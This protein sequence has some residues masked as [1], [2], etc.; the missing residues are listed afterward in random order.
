MPQSHTSATAAHP[1]RT[2]REPMVGL[3][4]GCWHKP[5]ALWP[6]PP[7][8][9]WV[10]GWQGVTARHPTTITCHVWFISLVEP[11]W[12]MQLGRRPRKA[13]GR[14]SRQE[15]AAT[16]DVAAAAAAVDR[17]VTTAATMVVTAAMTVTAGASAGR[18]QAGLPVAWLCAGQGCAAAVGGGGAAGGVSSGAASPRTAAAFVSACGAAA[19]CCCCPG[20]WREAVQRPPG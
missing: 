5:W 2:V 4:T 12:A 13:P 8:G 20:Q 15:A 14:S 6:R 1:S 18:W 19:V 3:R 10:P 7:G 9:C 17:C 11:C 16:S